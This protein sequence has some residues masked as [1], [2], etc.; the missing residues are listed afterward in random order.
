M[1]LKLYIKVLISFVLYFL[2]QVMI[3][4]YINVS[5]LNITPFLHLLF[6]LMLPF[7][8]EGWLM[9]L[10]SFFFGLGLDMFC[11]TLGINAA[12]CTFMAALRPVQLKL[13]SPRDGYENGSSPSLMCF[14]VVWFLKY[15][16]FLVFMHNILYFMLDSFSFENFAITSLK[17]FF[18]TIFTFVFHFIAQFVFYRRDNMVG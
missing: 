15:S 6:I 4:N 1:D 3:F 12:S 11:D 8:V 13:I 18:T 10:L 5:V 14:G 17:I 16:L 9:L 2:A 7:E